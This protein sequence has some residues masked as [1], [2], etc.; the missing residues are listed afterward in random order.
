MDLGG[1]AGWPGKG[2]PSRAS[3]FVGRSCVALAPPDTGLRCGPDAKTSEMQ[4]NPVALGASAEQGPVGAHELV[5]RDH[6]DGLKGVVG[7][8]HPPPSVL[9]AS[10]AVG[11]HRR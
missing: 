9:P 3:P 7:L 2:R 5:V 10:A 4:R 11:S 8:G 6:A 1:G